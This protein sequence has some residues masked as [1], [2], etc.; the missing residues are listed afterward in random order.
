MKD[1]AC[2]ELIQSNDPLAIALSILYDLLYSTN[3]GLE[4]NVKKELRC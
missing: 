2:E 4:Q 1:I 3:R